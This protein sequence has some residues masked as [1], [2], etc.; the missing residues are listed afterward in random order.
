MR[1]A[2][3]NGFQSP[4]YP[5]VGGGAR[6]ARPDDALRQMLQ[7]LIQETLMPDFTRARKF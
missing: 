1:K 2:I 3:R 4:P 7:T 6:E 5:I